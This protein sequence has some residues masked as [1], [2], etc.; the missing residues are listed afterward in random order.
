M[1]LNADQL[2]I[3]HN[4][5]NGHCLIKGVAGSGKTTVA[6]CRIPTLINQYLS[7]NE[8]ILI[9]TYNKTLI[10]Y[11]EHMYR[12]MDIQ[13]NLFFDTSSL[14]QIDIVTI[15][16]LVYQYESRLSSH[17]KRIPTN[18][19]RGLMLLAISQ[20]QKKYPKNPL[21]SQEN[22][23]FLSEEIDWIKSCRYLERETYLNTDRTGRMSIGE[24]K[25]R[26]PKNS[27]ARNAVFDLYLAYENCLAAKGFTD[28]KTSALRVLEAFEAHKLLPDKYTHVIVDESQD[29]TRVQ[30]ELVR[31][32][33]DEK[34][35][36]GS[37]M[38]IADAAQ[39]I[40]THSWLSSQSFKSIGFDMS[41]RSQILSKNYRTTYEIAQAAYSLI[42]KDDALSGNDNFVKPAAIE[43]H[44]EKPLYQ[45]FQDSEA[46]AAFIAERIK[47][48]LSDT[49]YTLKDMV[50]AGANTPYLEHIKN[51][52]LAHGIEAGIFDKNQPCFTEEKVVLYTLHSIKGLEFPVIFI[53]GIND[54]ILPYNKEQLS[55]GRR[56]FYVGMTRAKN[57]LYLSSGATPSVYM[58][59]MDH[60][61]LRTKLTEF[62]PFYKI[63]IGQYYFT[64][65]LA[66]I[67]SREEAVRQWYLHELMTK[68]NYKP[69]NIQLEYP[70][71]HFSSCG[72]V[73]ICIF[74]ENKNQPKPYI[75]VE[76]KQ[77][78]ENLKDALKQLHSYLS[79]VPSAK[80]AVVTN[81]IQTITEHLENGEFTP[82]H[83]LPECKENFENRIRTF[84]YK[85]LKN[86]KAYT[87]QVD[88]E[89]PGRIFVT[90]QSDG[91]P[92]S[93]PNIPLSIQGSIA[94][95]CLQ[96]I[97]EEN[98][99]Y[100]LVPEEFGLSDQDCFLLRV[101]G[102]SMIDFDI[103]EGD[104]IVIKKQN[105]ASRGEIVVAGDRTTNEATL[106]K[107]YPS[108]T[109]ITLI[110]GNNKYEPIFLRKED[111]FIN[112]ILV[113]IFS[114]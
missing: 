102:D 84:T 79:C 52:L 53:A 66:D 56:L 3:I 21:I 25:F 97:R 39:S 63:P 22:I 11:T 1:N 29:F 19:N 10:H 23:N 54:G 114:V 58:E 87:Y 55:I 50:V 73:D 113:G 36:H 7:Q 31:F 24:N 80:Y 38:F 47:A 111:F 81:G 43:R 28:F 85:S 9:V 33:Y 86:R 108:D 92:A 57:L 30:L 78:G 110:P 59:E 89:E 27:E 90:D 77:P 40:Y 37:I 88:T 2:K 99:G 4:K 14:N 44:G 48:L 65:Q 91:L 45:Q 101:T 41:G 18:Q 12:T 96:F 98:L 106:K 61:L 74:T 62:S 60:A 75:L 105:Y 68:L 100:V 67:Y 70:I 15:D 71:R 32:L 13:N 6:V 20:V 46:E 109:Q 83:T 16:K 72:F 8:R 17:F 51:Y 26:L 34:A 107:F 42:E 95:G 103:H 64:E 104:F 76:T 69:E 112:G 93:A 35:P 49:E 5:P 82:V 94:A